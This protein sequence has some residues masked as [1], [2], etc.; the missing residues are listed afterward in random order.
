MQSGRVSRSSCFGALPMEGPQITWDV[1]V[2]VGD[3][4]LDQHRVGAVVLDRQ[5]RD[6]PVVGRSGAATATTSGRRERCIGDL[7]PLSDH[8]SRAR[9]PCWGWDSISTLPGRAAHPKAAPNL[10]PAPSPSVG[11]S[12]RALQRAD[13]RCWVGIV[14]RAVLLGIDQIGDGGVG[15]GGRPLPV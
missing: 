10:S 3:Q 12:V 14:R 1:G 8:I 9:T 6:G 5:Q 7:D 2:G 15:S 11:P 13:H 4:L